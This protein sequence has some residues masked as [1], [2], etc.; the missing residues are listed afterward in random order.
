VSRAVEQD[1]SDW[2][3][4]EHSDFRV[5]ISYPA[6]TPQGHAV[7]RAEEKVEGH[8]VAGDFE[9]V[10]LSSPESGELYVEL[11]RFPDRTPAD[12]YAA[13]Q[14]YLAQR[15]GEDAVSELAESSFA[16]RSAWT[17][18]I[19]WDEGERSVLLLEV[20]GDTYRVIYDPRSELNARV[21]ATLTVD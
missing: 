14:P 12:E 10:H 1:A 15:F 7:D 20:E 3:R 19:R 8:P 9:R 4:V 5:S 18:G 11:A 6:V 13:H 2:E 16:G 17:Y 21:L